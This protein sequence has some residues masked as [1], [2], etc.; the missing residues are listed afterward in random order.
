MSDNVSKF[1]DGI[2]EQLEALQGRME[3]LKANIGTT[4]H[5]LHEKLAEVRD[6]QEATRQVITDARIRLEQW[7]QNQQGELKSTI[8][9]WVKR[10]ESQMLV[11]RAEQAESCAAL[12][13]MLARA[14]IDDAERMILEAVAARQDADALSGS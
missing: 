7:E 11:A 2:H 3:V 10:R 12:A 9:Q 4:W 6:K 1:C 8:D 5:S 13:L 14:S